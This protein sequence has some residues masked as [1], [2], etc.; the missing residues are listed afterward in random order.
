MKKTIALI[1]VL[2]MVCMS[3]F[4][5]DKQVFNHMSLG[6]TIGLEG[7]G[8]DL[9]LPIG[10][11]FQVRAGYGI[12]PIPLNFKV[13]LGTVSAGGKS[14]D[15]NNLPI[16]ANNW[17]TGTGHI[18][19]DYYPS[20]RSGF[21]ISAGVYLN[22]GKFLT[23]AADLSNVLNKSDWGTL[24]I[25]LSNN[26]KYV[27]TDT[28]GQLNIDVKHWN[29]MPYLGVGFGRAIDPKNVFRFVFDMGL[30]V[31]GSPKVQSYDYT[32]S[33]GPQT[34]VVTADDLRSKSKTAADLI[35]LAND[36]PVCPY[37]RFCFYFRLF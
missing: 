23:A 27:S 6:P 8:V 36:I 1:S 21:H 29:A 25:D 14:V 31:W 15:L 18:L 13:N 4:A 37:I 17:K 3:S 32:G 9:A 34:V 20:K 10:N 26:G 5:Q 24:A 2:C 35:Q 19:F 7:I 30:L 12:D 22:N 11:S 16:S 28:K 33:K